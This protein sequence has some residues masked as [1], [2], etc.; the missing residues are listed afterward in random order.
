MDRPPRV[1]GLPPG[2]DF[3]RALVA[4]LR[5]LATPEEPHA[6]ARVTVYLN[7][8]R[9]LRAVRA[10]FAE[11]PPGFLPRLRVVTEAADDPALPLPPAVPG[12]RRQLEL[13]VLI[14]RLLD[15]Q[16]DLAPR[17]A[18]HDLAESLADLLD[19]ME[20]EGVTPQ[21]IA[22]LDVSDHSAHWARTRAFLMLVAPLF[23]GEAAGPDARLR[24]AATALARRWTDH[25]P[26][27]PVY[28]AGS[29][30]SRGATAALM[31]AVAMLPQ[32]AL[33]LPGFDF[34]MPAEAWAA[35][36]DPL[37][38]EDH[39]QFRFVRL[40]RA[41]GLSP[42][43]VRPWPGAAPDPA[44]NR[45]LSLALRPAPVTDRWRAE[46]PGL[47]PL[48]EAMRNVALIEAPGPRAEANAIALALR[49][50]AAD[51]RTAAL[52]S[53]DRTLARMVTAA[54]DRWG[55]VPDDSGGEPLAL[56]PPGRFLR[57]VA[58]LCTAPP[59]AEALIALL[60]HPLTASEAERRQHLRATRAFE[61]RV[62][63]RGPAFPTGDALR[64]WG[65][66]PSWTAWVAAA[67]DTAAAVAAAGPMPLP[68]AAAA[69]RTLAEALA[70]GPG[71]GGSGALW[72]GAAGAT[73]RATLDTLAAEAVHGGDVT[74]TAFA[75]LLGHLLARAEVREPAGVPDPRIRLHG[76]LEARVQGADLVILG[77]LN[78]GSWPGAAPADPWLNRAM[79]AAAGLLL[80]ER[81]IGLAAH[82]F[83]Q[84]AAAPQVI[85]SRA[86]R[87]AD[88]ETTPA[89]WLNRLVNL[90]E[91][92][93][94]RDGPAALRAMRARGSALLA[95]AAALE[96]P[97]APV[98]RAPRPA[99]RPPVAARPRTLPVTAIRTLIRDPY[100]V[101]ARHILRLS[102]LDPL[103]AE[104]DARLRGSVLHRVLETFA[105]ERPQGE[106]RDAA[107]ARLLATAADVLT[108]LV[109]WPAARALW[110]A[111]LERAA[112]FLLDLEAANP[113]ETV[114][115]EEG[116]QIT[117]PGNGFVLTARPD[118]I[119]RLADG[120]LHILDY[121][122]GNPP[123]PKQIQHFDK[124]LLL[125]AA[126]ARAG[127]FPIGR[128][129]VARATYVGLGSTPRAQTVETDDA[130]LDAVL[131]DLVRLIDRYGMR[132]QGYT[133]RRAVETLGAVGD[134]DHLARFGEWSQ[135][136]PPCP[137]DVGP[138][139]GAG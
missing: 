46:G 89:R 83:Q 57:M 29:T 95:R 133:A 24:R 38:G 13:S 59:S 3:P 67:L 77:G 137:A 120:R 76:T 126:M 17:A 113:G 51:G 98:P 11:G 43:D 45:V 23:D 34:D 119:D 1:H 124:Q 10:A 7:S 41:L 44:R 100:A 12:L 19:E 85:L 18:L 5:A 14:A 139:E 94:E 33:I 102:P 121:K 73:A 47:P 8:A 75:D 27:G 84:A 22:D 68:R 9:M 31:R 114:L 48:P 79:R 60:K 115:L 54:L 66:E 40:L 2:A 129:T 32:G 131:N 81:R 15:A 80:P 30:A 134:Y 62:R 28:V 103:R 6:M 86:V 69:H 39:P 78:E 132:A 53:P 99:P 109:P 108:A 35:L 93:P 21:R 55:I 50:A 125:E 71:G 64:A 104:P 130:A 92:L 70:A 116:G 4:G 123:T 82:D 106:G 58:E 49:D 111:R 135:A 96:R 74:P 88:A 127:G 105:R 26:D 37:T 72:A 138:P 42:A 20:G 128:A 65:E 110:A 36:D 90:M 118:R 91:G 61:L 52:L 112:D 63:R 97:A 25:P 107:R 117:L 101:Y 122:T 136:D 16:P 56:T 87:D